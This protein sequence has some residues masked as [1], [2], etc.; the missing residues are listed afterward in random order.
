MLP[1]SSPWSP[2]ASSTVLL[3]VLQARLARREGQQGRS[4]PR[5]L[6]LLVD[7]ASNYQPKFDGLGASAAMSP[8]TNILIRAARTRISCPRNSNRGDRYR[9]GNHRG[10][11]NGGRRQYCRRSAMALRSMHLPQRG[12]C[13]HVCHVQR[14]RF[15]HGRRGQHVGRP[16]QL[17]GRLWVFGWQSF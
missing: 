14:R 4:R 10:I 1:A 8:N 7:V 13:V 9:G 15:L 5:R 2:L 3:R 16:G 6:V 12:I 11:G 17:F